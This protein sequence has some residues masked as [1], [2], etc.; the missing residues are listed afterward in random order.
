VKLGF[1]SEAEFDGI[2]DR[3]KMVKPYVAAAAG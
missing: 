3:A 1:V 2:V